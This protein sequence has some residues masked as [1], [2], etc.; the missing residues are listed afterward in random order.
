MRG[1]LLSSN[2]VSIVVSIVV[3]ILSV[4]CGVGPQ[5]KSSLAED[6]G[7]LEHD[8]SSYSE[9]IWFLP[10]D[11]T[12]RAPVAAPGQI[13]ISGRS[14]NSVRENFSGTKITFQGRVCPPRDLPRDVVFLI[15]VSASMGYSDGD[16]VVGG[17]CKRLT[18]LESMIAGFPAGTN[19]GVVAYE[20][21]ISAAS[22]SLF[23]TKAALYDDLTQHGSI[24]IANIICGWT[25]QGFFDVGMT[26]AKTL[27][28]MGRA[29][30]VQKDLVIITDGDSTVAPTNT[31]LM[32]GIQT[33][34]D[35]RTIG[36]V[37]G[38][39][40]PIKVQIAG[41]RV[42]SGQVDKYLA[43]TASAD[44]NGIT[45]VDDVLQSPRMNSRLGNLSMGVLS[46]ATLVYGPAGSATTTLID[47]KAGLA[48][49]YS[50][51][52]STGYLALSRDQIGYDVSVNSLDM[53]GNA[54]S[55]TGR[56]NWVLPT[57]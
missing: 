45:M 56:L 39:A 48:A 31:H 46:T 53:R 25:N 36:V 2:L 6:H 47:L 33:A 44:L 14:F 24:P 30:D 19:F 15:D 17:T 23:T 1:I 3:S 22:R 41:L 34:T 38:G 7:F 9:A 40:P 26:R 16:P 29:R 50:F 35:L 21:T 43:L 37:A 57:F 5:G 11:G 20:E 55:V 10:C 42:A 27:L 18:Q 32:T 13:V 51:R 52:V 12:D 8:K 4:S 28:S 54:N 49:D